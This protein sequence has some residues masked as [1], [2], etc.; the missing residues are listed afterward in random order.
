MFLRSALFGEMPG[1]HGFGLEDCGFFL[2]HSV[3]GRT[4]PLELG[5]AREFLDILKLAARL[6]FKP[7][8]VQIFGGRSEL[9]RKRLADPLVQQSR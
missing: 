7:T 4:H 6:A 8:P 2:D 1:K 5:V 3:Q 9:N